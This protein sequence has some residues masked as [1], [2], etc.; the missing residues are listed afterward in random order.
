MASSAAGPSSH[1]AVRLDV[2]VGGTTRLDA[3]AIHPDLESSA[4][5]MGPPPARRSSMADILSSLRIAHENSAFRAPTN[6]SAAD[7]DA[8]PGQASSGR[9]SVLKWGEKRSPGDEA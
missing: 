3:D 6:T 5:P 8:A 2:L 4:T 1:A 9:R 7:R